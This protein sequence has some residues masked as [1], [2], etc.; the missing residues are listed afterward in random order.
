VARYQIIVTDPAGIPAVKMLLQ[1]PAPAGTEAV[2]ILMLGH[3]TVLSGIPMPSI[4]NFPDESSLAAALGDQLAASPMAAHLYL[5]GTESFLGFVRRSAQE[6][7]VAQDA[8][9]AEQRG[10]TARD[11]QC[12]HCKTIYRAVEYRAFDC[13][14]CGVPLFVRDHYS[15][16]LAAYQAVV[17]YPTDPNLPLWRAEGF[18]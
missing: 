11:A 18:A 8:I 9:R 7:G 6:V 14:L 15:R 16:R 5:A 12:V 10:S 2:S 13:T 17:I 3:A 1:H 4:T